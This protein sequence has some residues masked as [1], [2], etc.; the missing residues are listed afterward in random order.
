LRLAQAELT[1]PGRIDT[2]AR[3]LGLMAPQPGQVV[4]PNIISGDPSAPVE[5]RMAAPAQP[6]H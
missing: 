4:H 2:M 5:A 6:A 1:Q 3:S